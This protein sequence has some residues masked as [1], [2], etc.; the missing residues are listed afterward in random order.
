MIARLAVL[1][2]VALLL[3]GCAHRPGIGSWLDAG[4][5]Y[6]ALSNGFS[7]ANPL[8]S[9]APTPLATA[10]ASIMLKQGA[11]MGFDYAGFDKPTVHHSIEAVSSG[12][13][14]WNLALLAGASTLT[15]IGAAV[16]AGFGYIWLFVP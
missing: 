1:A 12:A 3:T 9:W 6:V 14:G 2:L 15:G 13:A 5:T 16:L 8:L 10:V 4:T 11:K 7:E